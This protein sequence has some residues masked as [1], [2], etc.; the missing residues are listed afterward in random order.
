MKA[1]YR[2]KNILMFAW[3]QGWGRGPIVPMVLRKLLNTCCTCY[4]YG[5]HYKT[6]FLMSLTNQN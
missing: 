1:P 2:S 5:C 6:I 3:G 4:C